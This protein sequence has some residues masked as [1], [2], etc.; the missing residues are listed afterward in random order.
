MDVFGDITDRFEFD[1][2]LL[3]YVDAP[4]EGVAIE[5]TTSRR[6]AFSVFAIVPDQL[7]HWVLVP[8]QFG[9]LVLRSKPRA[10]DDMWRT[11]NF[12]ELEWL[13]VVEDA[14]EEPS[15]LSMARL[16]GHFPITSP[17]ARR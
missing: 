17:R 13:S 9:F 6:F 4:L 1:N 2:D 12:T 11:V 16:I 8:E 15:R 10:P 3:V 14:R 7:W 5:L